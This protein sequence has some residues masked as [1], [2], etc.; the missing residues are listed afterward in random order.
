[1]KVSEYVRCHSRMDIGMINFALQTAYRKWVQRR[2]RRSF[3]V[4]ITDVQVTA[5]AADIKDVR[6]CK[7]FVEA[8]FYYL[9]REFCQDKFNR[10][11]PPVNVVFGG[12]CWKRYNDY[13][14]RG[15]RDA[16]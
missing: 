3:P 4:K 6:E 13:I 10:P 15:I 7:L 12:K 16:E 8:Q 9:N 1:M 14:N 5:V 11:Y 2:A